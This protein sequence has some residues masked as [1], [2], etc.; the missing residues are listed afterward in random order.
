LR[1]NHRW[2]LPRRN[3]RSAISEIIG[4]LL[5]VL[6]TVAIGTLLLLGSSSS[7]QTGTVLQQSQVSLAT[8]QAQE[9]LTIFDV[10]FH[11]VGGIP[12]LEV[13][14]LNYGSN[15][16]HIVTIYTNQ[17]GTVAPLAS[18][19]TAYPNGLTLSPGQQIEILAAFSYTPGTNYYV[20]LVSDSGS[21]FDGAWS[22]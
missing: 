6:A 22:A 4:T 9:R 10:W 12:D 7:L 14:A 1:G 5:I 13:H 17:S 20:K 15:L 18:F 19:T 16:I 8:Q 11:T 21:V 2:V 3:G